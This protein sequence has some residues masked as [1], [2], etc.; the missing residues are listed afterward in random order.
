ML[1]EKQSKNLRNWNFI[2]SALHFIQGVLM[3]LISRDLKLPVNANYLNFDFASQKL[4]LQTTT[5]FEVNLAYLIAAF[6]FMSAIAHLLIATVFNKKY[7]DNLA[8][9]INK[10]RWIEYAFSASTMMVAISMLVG[11]YD[12]GS[13][14]MI[15][16]LIAIMNLMGLVMEVHN[17]TTTK[18][19]WLSFNIGCLAGIIPWIVV[20]LFFWSANKYGAGNIPTFVYYIYVS[21][22][23][24]FNCFAIN[25]Y[26]QYKKIGLWKNYL[27]G[28]KVYIILSL[29]AK[30]LLAWQVWAGTLRP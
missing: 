12:A 6:L 14:I 1:E 19:N 11:I 26:L 23:V 13:L 29:V 9:G 30:S 20:A 8:K 5:L 3:L 7:N 2:A 25:M 4:V 21:I 15:F 22:F 27:Y 24:F 17:Q 18:T 16:A 10:Y 28:E